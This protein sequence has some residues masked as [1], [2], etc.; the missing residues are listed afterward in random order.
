[1]LYQIKNRL[2]SLL[3]YGIS[4]GSNTKEEKQGRDI[5]PHLTDHKRPQDILYLFGEKYR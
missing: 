1:M 3:V 4:K 5:S 2:F